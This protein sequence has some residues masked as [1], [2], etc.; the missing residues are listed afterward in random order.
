MPNKASVWTKRLVRATSRRWGYEISPFRTGFSE[1]QRRLLS[2]IDLVVDVGANT[3]QYV[4]LVRQLGYS[5]RVLSFEPMNGAFRTLAGKAASSPH[6]EVRQKALGA[7]SGSAT[8]H[9]SSNSGSSSLLD[10]RDEHLRAAPRARVI[11]DELVEIATLDDELSDTPLQRTWLKLDVQGA[12]LGVLNGAA[13][14]MASVEVLQT[15]VSFSP[16][17]EGQADYLTLMA[18]VVDQGLTLRHIEPGFQDP[19]SGFLLQADALFVR[20]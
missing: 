9:L 10:I 3:G 4:E 2:E 15:E 7:E 13:Q 19:D 17:Y 12:E 1:V 11:G 6:W 5:G 8:L 20:D 16:L 18:W 14:V